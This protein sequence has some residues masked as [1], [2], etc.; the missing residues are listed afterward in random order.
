MLKYL[1]KWYNFDY[2]LLF[3]NSEIEKQDAGSGY[4]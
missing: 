4:S 1:V 3:H 2:A